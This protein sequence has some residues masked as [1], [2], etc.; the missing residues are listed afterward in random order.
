M[1]SEIP[2]KTLLSLKRISCEK[3]HE[4]LKSVESKNTKLQQNGVLFEAHCSLRG[5]LFALFFL[6]CFL[7]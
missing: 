5:W 7:L 2:P 4:G 3:L 6:N 1:K